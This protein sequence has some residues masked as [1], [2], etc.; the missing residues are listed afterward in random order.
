VDIHCGSPNAATAYKIRSLTLIDSHSAFDA[1]P[2]DGPPAC[3]HQNNMTC[4]FLFRS[5]ATITR[6]A[7]VSVVVVF[8]SAIACAL[9]VAALSTPDRSRSIRDDF[10]LHGVE[11]GPFLHQLAERCEIESARNSVNC[12][13]VHGGC[14]ASDGIAILENVFTAPRAT[15]EP[16]RPMGGAQ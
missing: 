5:T 4:E 15:R 2:P 6:R 10:V 11:R 9:A 8:V 7:H 16:K 14:S 12:D 13:E 3:D 1:I